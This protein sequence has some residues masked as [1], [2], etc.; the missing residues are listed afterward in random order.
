M[1]H[2]LNVSQTDETTIDDAE[3]LDLVMPVYNLIEN[4]NYSQIILKQQEVYGFCSKDEVTNFN[5]VIENTDG[6][7]SFKY[8]A[9]LLENIEADGA[10][11]ILKNV[12][13]IFKQFLEITRNAI[14]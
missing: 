7:K 3:N 14:H 5:A 13:K 9:K 4:A 10:N 6:F 12:I 1:H 8:K 11:G 2:L